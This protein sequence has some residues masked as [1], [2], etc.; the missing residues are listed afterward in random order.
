[1]STL[2][3]VALLGRGSLG[4]IVL[5]ELLRARF[6]VTVLTRSDSTSTAAT[7]PVGITLKQVDYSSLESL[8]SALQGHDIVISTLTP[9]AIPL[10]KLIIDASIAVG[11]TRFIP[12]DYGAICSDPSGAAQKLPCHAPAVAIQNYLRERDT[13]IEHTIFAVGAL[14]ERI[15]T[16]PVAVDLAHRAVRLYDGGVH[17]FSVSRTSTVAKAVVGALQKLEETRNRVVRVH[18]AVLTQRRVY[19]LARKWTAGE[20]WTETNVD[21]EEQ[22]ARTMAMLQKNPDPALLPAMFLAAFFS[23]KF[24]AEYRDQDLDNELLGLGLLSDEEVERLGLE[25]TTGLV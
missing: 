15:F 5:D 22:L 16:L 3:K 13:Q 7:L 4:S 8:Q 1:M 2:Q 11:V 23:G 10:Q 17:A 12:A 14:L 18:D 9:A 25:L 20:Q 6:T 24:G 21:A 19:N